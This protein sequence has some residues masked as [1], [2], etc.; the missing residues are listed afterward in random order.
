MFYCKCK[1]PNILCFISIITPCCVF[2]LVALP[3]RIQYPAEVRAPA[4]VA[5]TRIAVSETRPQ[6]GKRILEERR[7]LTQT[8]V[9]DDWFV[10]LDVGIKESGICFF[11]LF[12]L[13][14]GFFFAVKR[15]TRVALSSLH[16]MLLQPV[17]RTHRVLLCECVRRWLCTFTIIQRPL[18]LLRFADGRS[19]AF[20]TSA[21]HQFNHPE[22]YIPPCGLTSSAFA[23]I[24]S[25][26][27]LIF[28]FALRANLIALIYSHF[29]DLR[30]R[31]TSGSCPLQR[32]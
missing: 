12:V 27:D 6:F 18:T 8:H 3:E 28:A 13:G 22:L 29:V 20:L 30:F 21:F 15:L 4:A 16:E 5:K 23:S 32:H 17:K 7:P 11:N 1:C 10:L 26:E 14:L 9:N 25:Q 31:R 2:V 24:R 19:D